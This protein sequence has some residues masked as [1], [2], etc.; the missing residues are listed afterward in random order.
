MTGTVRRP[1]YRPGPALV[2]VL[3]ALF[4]HVV[5]GPL[6]ACHGTGAVPVAVVEQHPAGHA[7]CAEDHPCQHGPTGDHG[8]DDSTARALDAPR[9]PAAVLPLCPAPAR[10]VPPVVPVRPSGP[11]ELL[12]VRE[13]VTVLCVDRN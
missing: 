5:L 13:P 8:T 12:A 7:G 3:L 9:T 4:A 1:T 2:V 6:V 11:V 10:A